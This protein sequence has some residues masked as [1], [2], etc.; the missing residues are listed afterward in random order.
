M[1]GG[2]A[3]RGEAQAGGRGVVQ[4]QGP[5]GVGAEVGGVVVEEGQ[6]ARQLGL[7]VDQLGGR[8]RGER[9]QV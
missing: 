9:D 3:G 2:P 4:G 8:E 1:Q 7:L 6:R 5:G